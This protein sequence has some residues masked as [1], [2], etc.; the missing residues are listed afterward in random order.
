[1]WRGGGG[2]YWPDAGSDQIRMPGAGI[3]SMWL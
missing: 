3:V 1:M 2:V